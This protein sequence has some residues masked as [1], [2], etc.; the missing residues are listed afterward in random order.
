MPF[1]LKVYQGEEETP[2][3]LSPSI[4]SMTVKL[5]CMDALCTRSVSQ[6]CAIL[7]T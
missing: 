7:D 1:Y 2:K 5:L 6:N 3:L 4:A